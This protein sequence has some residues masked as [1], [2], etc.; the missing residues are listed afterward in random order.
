[1]LRFGARDPGHQSKVTLYT[2]YGGLVNNVEFFRSNLPARGW[3]EIKSKASLPLPAEYHQN[4]MFH[5]GK[6]ELTVN[7]TQMDRE[8]RVRVHIAE[9]TGDELGYPGKAP[10]KR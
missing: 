10:P 9:A 1:M 2:N 3:V 7:L 6:R 4:L 5:K 8:G